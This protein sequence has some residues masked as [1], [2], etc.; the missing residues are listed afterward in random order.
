MLLRADPRGL[1]FGQGGVKMAD[2]PKTCEPEEWTGE[3]DPL[4]AKI[5]ALV[6]ALGA[7]GF[8]IIG[9]LTLN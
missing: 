1:T 3:P 6:L 7:I 9:A 2:A 5:L 4:A 8:V